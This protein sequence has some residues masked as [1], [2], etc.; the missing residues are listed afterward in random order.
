MAEEFAR[1]LESINSLVF[2]R[3]FVQL[4]GLQ[5]SK[6]KL[7]VVG[8]A[9]FLNASRPSLKESPNKLLTNAIVVV[10]HDNKK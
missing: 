1:C 3:L 7:K 10:R 9:S 6:A 4:R 8:T 5:H 2:R